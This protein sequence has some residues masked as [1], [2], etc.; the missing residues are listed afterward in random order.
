MRMNIEAERA[1]RGL[2][3]TKMAE[4]LGIS[5]QTYNS[6]VRGGQIP[7]EKLLKMADIFGVTCDYLLETASHHCSTAQ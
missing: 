6:Y 2:S 7:S 5:A 4:I 1:R 3:K